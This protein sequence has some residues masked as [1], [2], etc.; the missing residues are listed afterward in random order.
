MN[1]EKAFTN[2]SFN[3]L[4]NSNEFINLILNNIN[5]CVL[6]LDKDVKLRAFNNV[7]KDNFFE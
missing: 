6:L 1:A 2:E 3:F 4:Q 5:S 7:L